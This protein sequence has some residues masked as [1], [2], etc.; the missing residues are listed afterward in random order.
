MVVYGDKIVCEPP[1][2]M[3]NHK[4]DHSN[5][6]DWV[7]GSLVCGGVGGQFANPN[8]CLNIIMPAHT[9]VE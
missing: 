4:R 2:I 7:Y 8:W 6:I 1:K 3:R 9:Y 5:P